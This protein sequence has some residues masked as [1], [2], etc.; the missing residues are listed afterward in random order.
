M[1]GGCFASIHEISGTG[2]GGSKSKG[3]GGG[4]GSGKGGGGGGGGRTREALRAAVLWQLD[5]ILLSRSLWK[6]HSLESYITGLDCV[7][8]REF[9]S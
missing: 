8:L 5:D 4:N 2:G 3:G 9:G 7:R 6:H 1:G